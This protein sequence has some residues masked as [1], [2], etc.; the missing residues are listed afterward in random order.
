MQFEF[1]HEACVKYAELHKHQF[2]VESEELLNT[3][4][5]AET[6][7]VPALPPKPDEGLRARRAEE[8]KRASVRA[9]KSMRRGGRQ[10][11]MS[12]AQVQRLASASLS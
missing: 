11:L 6:D 8:K 7:A 1:V 3:A 9:Q 4:P 2:L 5:E 12:R 10:R